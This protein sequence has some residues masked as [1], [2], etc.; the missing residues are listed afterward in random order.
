MYEKPG[1]PPSMSHTRDFWSDDNLNRRAKPA[2][3]ADYAPG[4]N[5]SEEDALKMSAALRQHVSRGGAAVPLQLAEVE[6]Y[7]GSISADP[8][9]PPP[10]V[11]PPPT[12]ST[13]QQPAA[14]PIDRIVDAVMERLNKRLGELE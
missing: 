12:Y 13:Q 7:D 6:H 1:L 11:Q 4:P 14:D 5:E 3:Y 9:T 2:S 8:S 10:M